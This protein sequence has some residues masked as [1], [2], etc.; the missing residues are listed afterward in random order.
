VQMSEVDETRL[1]DE[2]T[3]FGIL[4]IVMILIVLVVA[5]S[6]P[7]IFGIIVPAVLGDGIDILTQPVE[8]APPSAEEPA[9]A[10]PTESTPASSESEGEVATPPEAGAEEGAEAQ[11][12]EPLPTLVTAKTHVVRSGETLTT[13]STIP[14]E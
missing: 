14:Q 1:S 5:L 9:G 10:E 2:W 8:P 11:Q 3:K 13:I 12:V 6:R 7:L 4:A